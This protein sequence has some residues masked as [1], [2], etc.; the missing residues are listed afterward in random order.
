[1]SELA[2][3]YAPGYRAGET[4]PSQF[5]LAELYSMARSAQAGREHG[6]PAW[7]QDKLLDKV[8]LEGRADAGYN[9]FNTNNPRAVSLNQIVRGDLLNSTVPVK[10]HAMG[11]P[12]AILDKTEVADRLGIKRERAWNGTGKSNDTGRTGAQHAQRAAQMAGAQDDP[13]NAAIKDFMTRAAKDDL[14]SPEYLAV[15]TNSRS[16]KNGGYYDAF[17]DSPETVK[18]IMRSAGLDLPESVQKDLTNPQYLS[19]AYLN[20]SGVKSPA[21]PYPWEKPDLNKPGSPTYYERA[22]Y[23]DIQQE[24]QRIEAQ[25]GVKQY[26]DTRLGVTP[27]PEESW[28]DKHVNLIKGMFSK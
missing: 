23:N 8:L 19:A 20:R 18:K 2:S 21:K 9:R 22:R 16:P 13:R 15:L 12:S 14:T 28:I 3:L 10:E 24:L 17:N 25:P 6:M 27:A 5:N 7:G 4:L 1:M 26:L 11:Y